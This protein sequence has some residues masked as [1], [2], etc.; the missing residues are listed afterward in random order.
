MSIN[1]LEHKPSAPRNPRTPWKKCRAYGLS[2][3]LVPPMA[4]RVV[5]QDGMVI[6]KGQAYKSPDL[7]KHVGVEVMLFN[8]DDGVLGICLGSE[9]IC[10]IANKSTYHLTSGQRVR[11]SDGWEEG[12]VMYCDVKNYFYL[13]LLDGDKFFS[14]FSENELQLI[15]GELS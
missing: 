7:V 4:V 1:T 2:D 14:H 15:E 13:V 5:T 10:S 8:L 6:F 12:T 9:F 11:T 3:C